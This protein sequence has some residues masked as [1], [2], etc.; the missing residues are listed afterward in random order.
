MV[1]RKATWTVLLFLLVGAQALATTCAVRCDAMDAMMAASSGASSD[2]TDCHGLMSTQAE[3][4]N[5]SDMMLAANHCAAYACQGDL[6]PL[7]SRSSFETASHA[8]PWI[9]AVIVYV[10]HADTFE[11]ATPLRFEFGR[12]GRFIPLFDPLN[13]SLRV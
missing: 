13:S 4:G 10:R 2:M 8:G 5:G 12:R 9:A 7:Q 3:D 11:I 6:T 1:I